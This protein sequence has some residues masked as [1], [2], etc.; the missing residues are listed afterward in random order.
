MINETIYFAVRTE[1][2]KEE[3]NRIMAIE[4][5][6]MNFLLDVVMSAAN[7]IYKDFSQAMELHPFWINYPLYSVEEHHEVPPFLG[8]K[9]V[10]RRL[11]LALFVQ[12]RLKLPQ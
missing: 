1:L 7:D 3:Q 6:H 9:L 4:Q 2:L 5:R 10:K 12:Y 8:A 11:V